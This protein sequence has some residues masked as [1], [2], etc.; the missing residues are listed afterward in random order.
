MVA[1]AGISE[2]MA[3]HFCRLLEEMNAGKSIS[4]AMEEMEA[5]NN[6]HLEDVAS[7]SSY[8]FLE[9]LLLSAKEVMRDCRSGHYTEPQIREKYSI[10]SSRLIF[11]QIQKLAARGLY[12][13]SV[14]RFHSSCSTPISPFIYAGFIKSSLSSHILCTDHILLLRPAPAC[15]DQSA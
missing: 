5:T 4:E 8:Y 15:M 11:T 13:R 14:R 7:S 2:K 1:Q 10:T 6:E 9:N 3:P 12:H